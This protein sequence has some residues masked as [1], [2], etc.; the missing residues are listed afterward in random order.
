[1]RLKIAKKLKIKNFPAA[2]IYRLPILGGDL[3]ILN[4]ALT[5]KAALENDGFYLVKTERIGLENH[6]FYYANAPHFKD[7]L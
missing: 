6:I 1:M 3:D 4:K 7:L 5:D 2:V